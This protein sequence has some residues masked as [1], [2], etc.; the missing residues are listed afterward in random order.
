MQLTF[1]LSGKSAS[2]TVSD[3]VIAGWTGRDREAVEHHIAELQALGVR[4]PRQVP[5]FYRLASALLTME[6]SIDTIGE[7]SSGEVEFVLLSLEQGLCV[8]VGSDHTDR[9]VEAYGVTVSK[10]LCAKPIGPALWRF[11]EV[12]DHWDQLT[13]RSYVTRGGIRTLYQEGTVAQMRHP[14]ELIERFAGSTAELPPGAVMFCGTLPAIGPIAGGE[15]L[16]LELWDPVLGQSLQHAYSMR[17][18]PIAD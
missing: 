2:M 11:S 10:Q 4:P 13:L 16:E 9:K 1:N 5:T 15:R 14:L 17:Q 6:S 3:L 18:L 7:D 12:Q 8:G